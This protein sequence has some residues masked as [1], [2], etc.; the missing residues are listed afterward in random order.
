MLGANLQYFPF[1][2]A[3]V[4][5]IR[6]EPDRRQIAP[7]NASCDRARPESPQSE[8]AV[9]NLEQVEPSPAARCTRSFGAFA[10]ISCRMCRSRL[11]SA[12][13]HV[14]F[15]SVR[16]LAQLPQSFKTSP[17]WFFFHQIEALLTN[18]VLAA[19][20]EIV[21]P[22]S[23]SRTIRLH[24]GGVLIPIGIDT[25]AHGATAGELFKNSN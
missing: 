21:A 6:I 12:T 24:H 23:T 4:R 18:S 13:N 20:L 19:D 1:Q 3:V 2:H 8:A 9:S 5:D 14:N 16:R 17:A 15:D 10:T 22:A 7:R 11:R 25:P